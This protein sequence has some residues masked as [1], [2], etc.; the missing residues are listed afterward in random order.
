MSLIPGRSC[1]VTLQNGLITSKER[2]MQYSSIAAQIPYDYKG[3]DANEYGND[4]ND[5][6]THIWSGHLRGQLWMQ[7]SWACDNLEATYGIMLKGPLSHPLATRLSR[8]HDHQMS[9]THFV[10]GVNIYITSHK[11]WQFFKV[12]QLNFL[13]HNNP[14]EHLDNFF[15]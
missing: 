2:L 1:I 6:D 4:M 10:E 8:L 5:M 3:I 11:A 9:Q 14:C 7:V 15:R 13:K 12:Q